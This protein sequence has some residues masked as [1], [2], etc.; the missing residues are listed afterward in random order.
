MTQISKTQPTQHLAGDSQGLLFPLSCQ[1]QR[2]GGVLL[3]G[4][5]RKQFAVL[6]NEAEPFTTQRAEFLVA[7][8]TEDSP[9]EANLAARYRQNTGQAVQQRGLT[10][11]TVP[12]NGCDLTAT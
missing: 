1:T 4:E 9:L 3:Y 10:G 7:E 11:A 8:F 5:L 12:G 2:Q 6:E